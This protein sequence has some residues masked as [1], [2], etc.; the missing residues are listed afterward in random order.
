MSNYRGIYTAMRVHIQHV[1]HHAM[2]FLQN[3]RNSRTRRL[4][5]AIVRVHQGELAECVM[6]Q[7]YAT[8]RSQAG[9]H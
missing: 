5:R 8:G 7:T 9:I 2:G 3:L 6:A 4:G 1:G